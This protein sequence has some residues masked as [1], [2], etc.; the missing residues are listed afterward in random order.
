MKKVGFCI[1]ILII[2]ILGA[3][4]IPW[5][6]LDTFKD[7][8]LGTNNSYA[9]LKIFSLGGDM[10][11]YLDSEEKGIVKSQDPYLEVFPVDIG[12]HVVKL[13]RVSSQEGFYDYFEKEILFEKGFDTVIS[14]EIGPTEESSSGWILYAQSSN[15]KKGNA[16]LNISSDIE[17]CNVVLNNTQEME[18]PINNEAIGLDSQYN[19]KISKEGFQDL[20]FQILPEDQEARNRLDG[21]ILYVEVNLYKIPI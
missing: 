21:Y 17:T 15:E 4:L 10:K 2:G 7:K 6:R 16:L 14:W 8:M 9:S 18:T 19:I 12:D 1:I 5:H 3:I 11:V 13:E 20:E